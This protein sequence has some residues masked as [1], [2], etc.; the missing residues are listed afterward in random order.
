MYSDMIM[1]PRSCF[2]VVLSFLLC[3]ALGRADDAM[4]DRSSFFR[5]LAGRDTLRLELPEA[6]AW[7]LDHNPTVTIERREPDKARSQVREQGALWDPV[8]TAGGSQG[9]G[10]VPSPASS[11]GAENRNTAALSAGLSQALPTG[12]AI[13]AGLALSRSVS[14]LYSDQAAGTMEL[15][16]TQALLRGGGPA[17]G[18]AGLRKA[19]LDVRIS[20]EELQAVAEEVVAAV[21]KGYWDLYL[22]RQEILIQEQSFGLAGQLL[23]ESAERVAVGK[24]PEVELAAVRAEVASRQKTLIDAQARYEQARLLFLFILNPANSDLGAMV[25]VPVNE[26]FLPADSLEAV[27][28]HEELGLKYRP[29]LQ[30]ARLAWQQGRL[31]VARTRNG[32]LPRLDFYLNLSRTSYARTLKEAVPDFQAPY[33]EGSAGLT[34]FF[35]LPNRQAR[36]QAA[37]ARLTQEQNELALKN[38]EQLVRKDVRSAYIEVLRTRQ[39]IRASRVARSLQEQKLAAEQ[40]KFRVGRSTNYLVLQTQRDLTAARL[41]E[42]RALVSHLNALVNLYVTEG[43]LLDRRGYSALPAG[44]KTE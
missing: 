37:R 21:E 17:A 12:T 3:L 44:P 32:L 38:L 29:D 14:S 4:P 13:T 23:D 16:I 31:E 19:A 27:A 30:Q 2:K 28:T 9:K 33:Y 22:A 15:T 34:F 35:P 1:K 7:A 39:Q 5:E 11:T 40:E 10:K 42:A 6:I 18:L 24:L 8:L 25:P 41:D 26:P 36:A 43:T 20:Q